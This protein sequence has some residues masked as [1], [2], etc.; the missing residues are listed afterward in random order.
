MGDYGIC[1]LCG[2]DG[3]SAERSPNGSIT[4]ANGHRYPHGSRV[5]PACE[6][7]VMDSKPAPA[8]LTE[9]D[10]EICARLLSA[11]NGHPH[12]LIPWPHR[13]LHDAVAHIT[14]LTRR[15]AEVEGERDDLL[16]REDM[17]ERTI[18]DKWRTRKYIVCRDYQLADMM[19]MC[20]TALDQRDE[21]EAR[22]GEMEWLVEVQRL[23]NWA[24]CPAQTADAHDEFNATLKAALAA[25]EG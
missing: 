17:L 1:P 10:G 22:V 21:S 6:P 15:L 2:A 19:A 5:Y 25:V 24:R 13:L 16:K 9:E 23:H 12:A 11:C 18:D 7:L 4:C 3:V 8:P 20:L 14:S